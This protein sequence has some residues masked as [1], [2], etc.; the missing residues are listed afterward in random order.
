LHLRATF[1]TLVL[2]TLTACGGGGGEAPSARRDQAAAP[3]A[4]PEVAFTIADQ[5]VTDIPPE[6][7]AGI[8]TITITNNG[9]DKHFPGFARINEGVAKQKVGIAL[10]KGD[11]KTFFTSAVIAGSVFSEGRLNLLPGDTGSI[12][13][14]L[15]EGTY[16]LADP[17]AK[18]F[19]PGFFSVGPAG[20]VEAETPEAEYEIVEGEYYIEFPKNLPAGAHTFALTNAGEQAHELIIMDKKTEKE[21]G[22]T[23]AP[24]P[25]S[26]SWVEFDLEP[27]TYV[28]ACYFPDVKKGKVGKPHANLGMKTTVTVK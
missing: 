14:E 26:T 22:Y 12:T 4:P 20:N 21:V 27:G 19:E 18:R 2:L 7:N 9:E 11:F 17:E 25:G 1:T 13:T 3:V 23:F 15:P 16:I 28:L 24:V 6:I 5:G 8:N 10:A